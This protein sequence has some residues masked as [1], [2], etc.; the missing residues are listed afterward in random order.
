[1]SKYQ[2]DVIC[3]PGLTSLRQLENVLLPINNLELTI[4]SPQANITTMEPP[5][6]INGLFCFLLVFIVTF[7]YI[8]TSDTNLAAPSA[9]FT[10]VGCI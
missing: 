2:I 9:R 10:L 5:F 8:R 7:E 3:R 1:M 4:R 6:L